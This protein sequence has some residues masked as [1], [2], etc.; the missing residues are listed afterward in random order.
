MLSPSEPRR[1]TRY[2]LDL[3]VTVRLG[4]TQMSARSENISETGILLSSDFLILQG[5]SVELAVHLTDAL[6]MGASLTARGKVLRVNPKMS[7]GFA[8]AIGCEAP[9]RITR[10]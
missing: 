3:P 8:M 6:E 1:S 2:R 5:A 10:H 4:D 7:G 9:F